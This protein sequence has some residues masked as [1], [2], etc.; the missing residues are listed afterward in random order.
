MDDDDH[1]SNSF[2]AYSTPGSRLRQVQSMVNFDGTVSGGGSSED[3]VPEHM[4]SSF[5][6]TASSF[7]AHSMIAG[8]ADPG[9]TSD[10]EEEH[11]E[12]EPETMV[13]LVGNVRNK[14]VILLDDMID[15]AGSWVAAAETVVKRGGAVRVYC[16]ATH[17]LFGENCL[18]QLEAC[19]EIAKVVVTNSFPIPEEKLAVSTKLEVLDVSTLLAEA[20]R[21]NKFGETMSALYMHDPAL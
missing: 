7:R 14:P 19:D 20:I 17:G 11:I 2:S 5:V 9:E 10:E 8:T 18:E 13:T 1:T 3:D 4:M 15:K 12:A 6:S 16:I 21:R